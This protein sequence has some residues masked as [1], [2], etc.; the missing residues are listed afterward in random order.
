[1]DD[2][3]CIGPA[4]AA[5]DRYLDPGRILAAAHQLQADAIHP[6]YGFLS[7][8]AAFAQAVGDAGLIFVGPSPKRSLAAMGDK[9]EAKR[10][11]RHARLA[12]RSSP[13]TTATTCTARTRLRAEAEKIGTPV[14]VKAS[15]GGGGRGMRVVH[16]L[17]E[18]TEAVEAAKRE[19]FA[20]FGDDRV[21]LERYLA[22][23]RH[24]EFQIIAD[25]YG[26]VIHLGERECSIQRR[27][28]KIIEEAPSYRRSWLR[29]A[30]PHGRA[31]RF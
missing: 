21:L 3:V 22:R 24:I 8:R 17:A 7:E 12:F 10:R 15:A 30:R 18:F 29:I 19:A 13:G 14:L 16:D 23:P 26:N 20:A 9:V 6:G 4:E 2:A 31:L 25:G 27:H 11:V 28:Q 5:A 1:M